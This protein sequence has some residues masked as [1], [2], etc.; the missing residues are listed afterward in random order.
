M[1]NKPVGSLLSKPL[2]E[3]LS[4]VSYLKFLPWLTFMMDLYPVRW[5]KPLSLQVAFGHGISHSNCK[6]NSL[7]I[8]IDGWPNCYPFLDLPW[9][10]WPLFVFLLLGAIPFIKQWQIACS[11]IFKW[12]T[13]ILQASPG[14]HRKMEIQ[15]NQGVCVCNWKNP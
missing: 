15:D 10:S 7:S 13:Y 4:P 8:A 5:N 14:H 12:D 2:F 3:F 1:E 9:L 6:Q 11:Y